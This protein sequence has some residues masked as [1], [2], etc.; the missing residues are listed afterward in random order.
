MFWVSYLCCHH[1]LTIVTEE[2]WSVA[3]L[4]GRGNCYSTFSH[5][6]TFSERHHVPRRVQVDITLTPPTSLTHDNLP[7]DCISSSYRGHWGNLLRGPI[8]LNQLSIVCRPHAAHLCSKIPAPC[9]SPWWHHT[10][11]WCTL[12]IVSNLPV[13]NLCTI[14][15]VAGST[16]EKK[17]PCTSSYLGILRKPFRFF[18][19][20]LTWIVIDSRGSSTSTARCETNFL[21]WEFWQVRLF[22]EADSISTYNLSWWLRFVDICSKN[23]FHF[24]TGRTRTFLLLTGRVHSFGPLMLAVFFHCI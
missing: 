6:L 24:F 21:H 12:A 19:I 13:I 2:W 8:L 22:E 17:N 3:S 18:I 9:V 14:V 10:H 4:L 11:P 1:H 5:S 16:M 7:L 23:F 15:P 20:C